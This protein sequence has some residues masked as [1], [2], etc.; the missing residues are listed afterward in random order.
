MTRLAACIAPIACVA[1]VACAASAPSPELPSVP[2]VSA[3]E[4]AG[5]PDVV[6]A[7]PTLEL[8]P[9]EARRAPVVALPPNATYEQALA[10][11]EAL[12]AQDER[13]HLTDAQLTAPMRNVPG[14][15]AIPRKGKVT[16]KVAVQQGHAIGVTVIVS[17]F[18]PE[19]AKV[20]A[21][22]KRLS[23]KAAKERARL[24][25]ERAK[26]EKERVKAEAKLIARVTECFDT[27]VRALQWAPNARRDS[28]TTMY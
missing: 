17:L 4:D 23:A 2:V 1:G 6:E 27:A 26:A 10:V 25:K 8:T 20:E 16:V 15:C 22:P 21:A 18:K 14:G 11:P 9:P 19:V 24:E 12:N 7:S 3:Q 28:F 13:A 5:V